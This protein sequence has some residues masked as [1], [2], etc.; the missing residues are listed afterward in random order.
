MGDLAKRS[1]NVSGFTAKLVWYSRDWVRVLVVSFV[2]LSIFIRHFF[3]IA[4]FAFIT[5]TII[6]KICFH[7]R[8]SYIMIYFSHILKQ[9]LGKRFKRN[10]FFLYCTPGKLT[11]LL[12][13][14]SAQFLIHSEYWLTHHSF[15][16]AF[17]YTLC[18]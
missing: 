9:H 15:I 1:L 2:A 5:V 11:F 18:C 14:R 7:I 13:G 8:R 6:F 17:D 4:L 12:S 16:S 10:Q 3:A